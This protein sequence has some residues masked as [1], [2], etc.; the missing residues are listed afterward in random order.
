MSE[1]LKVRDEGAARWI[2]LNRPEALNA[3]NDEMGEAFVAALENAA[4]D[5]VRCVV[6]TG[7]GKAFCAGEDLRALS[8]DYESGKAPDLGEIL[9]RRYNPAIQLIQS[10]RKPVVAAV[11]GVAAGAGMSLALACDFRVMAEEASLVLAF[12]KVGLV[13]DSGGTW[14]L[15]RYVGVGR[16]MELCFT[17]DPVNAARALE[18][19]LVNQIAPAP[20][21]TKLAGEIASG[22]AEGPTLAF[23]LVKELVWNAHH[24]NL[25]DQLEAEADA[26]GEA[27]SSE[28]HLEGVKAFV[29][30]R[31]PK[32]QGR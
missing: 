1:T 29:Q 32:F 16:A 4:D 11:N 25:S 2:T 30:K 17:G 24:T 3:F 5:S 23:G 26:Q 22:F 6:V 19:G 10:L 21:V 18:L 31:P 13:P 14:L 20:D 27:G 12:P 9:R 28:D 7:E 8:G 15:P